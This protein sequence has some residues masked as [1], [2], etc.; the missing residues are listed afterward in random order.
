MCK[1]FL[2]P[3]SPIGFEC[4]DLI[5]SNIKL[6]QKFRDKNHPIFFTTTIYRN[7][8]RVVDLSIKDISE[9]FNKSISN[10]MESN[11]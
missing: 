11:L 7:E 8:S 3:M 5:L 10:R 4:N 6:V 1:G 9:T 2:D